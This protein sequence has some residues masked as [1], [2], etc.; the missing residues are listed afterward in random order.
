[1]GVVDDEDGSQHDD[2]EF[3]ASA[4]FVHERT[5]PLPNQP[6]PTHGFHK[7][8]FLQ[9]PNFRTCFS[10]DDL[11]KIVGGTEYMSDNYHFLKD[12]VSSASSTMEK[13]DSSNCTQGYYDLGVDDQT[14]YDMNKNPP[15]VW[16]PEV[17]SRFSPPPL[18]PSRSE[19]NSDVDVQTSRGK[20][21]I[22][23]P[24]LPQRSP[25]RSRPLP[26]PKPRPEVS[27]S[28]TFSAR[29]QLPSMFN[30]KNDPKFTKKLEE[31]RQELYGESGVIVRGRSISMG[32]VNGYTQENYASIDDISVKP[33]KLT[34]RVNSLQYDYA[35]TDEDP[36]A[37]LEFES[38]ISD[39]NSRAGSPPP[40]VPPKSDSLQRE[41]WG[42]RHTPG[43]SLPLPPLP[44]RSNKSRSHSPIQHEA[45]TPPPLPSRELS[46]PPCE[47]ALPPN[48]DN[49][50]P[51]KTPPPCDDTPP[52][53]PARLS[54]NRSRF[55][56]EPQS[57]SHQETESLQQPV[58]PLVRHSSSP[59]NSLT[60]DNRPPAMLP[61]Q[62]LPLTSNFTQILADIMSSPRAQRR[63]KSAIITQTPS[64]QI[65]DNY[66]ISSDVYDDVQALTVLTGTRYEDDIQLPASHNLTNHGEHSSREKEFTGTYDDMLDTNQQSF[67]Q[68]D[69]P[70]II[71]REESQPN[72]ATEHALLRSL[73]SRL[74]AKKSVAM[75][76]PPPVKP[77][78]SPEKKPKPRRF[79]PPPIMP[80]PGKTLLGNLTNKQAEEVRTAPTSPKKTTGKGVSGT[81]Q[82]LMSRQDGDVK[83]TFKPGKPIVPGKPVVAEKPAKPAVASKPILPAHNRSQANKP[84]SGQG[85]EGE[86]KPNSSEITRG[87]EKSVHPVEPR[88]SQRLTQTETR[89]GPPPTAPRT[90]PPPIAPRTGPPPIAPRTGPPLTAPRTGPPPTAP[91][92][93]P[94]LT[95][96]KTGGP[97]PPV[98][99]KANP[100]PTESVTGPSAAAVSRTGLS[101]GAGRT[102]LSSRAGRT[103]L[104]SA[105]GRTGP[106]PVQHKSPKP[107]QAPGIT[108][109]PWQRPPAPGGTSEH[110]PPVPKPSVRPKP[111]QVTG[112]TFQAPLCS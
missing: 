46:Y 34:L 12:N 6:P 75:N 59:S 85:T 4:D 76:H 51:I 39:S 44:L 21:H 25:D 29:M 86:S 10:Q 30:F 47:P 32:E 43:H 57:P 79:Q 22:M 11:H 50:L 72:K 15:P 112:K 9:Q 73:E 99:A 107:E 41:V 31:K 1:M 90:G 70:P 55:G 77:K 2:E 92:T 89:A 80:K 27:G 3:Y 108:S 111:T 82:P 16:K 87:A 14:I 48:I 102:G 81:S 95:G 67:P 61:Q 17:R 93:G 28:A 7:E 37:Y 83:S 36:L 24:V 53:V 40:E 101:S 23:S 35:A 104:S 74:Q 49:R 97:L 54:S 52:P 103:G 18:P 110:S 94:P 100:L 78:I 42:I 88:V 105:A 38:S 62:S 5:P 66:E 65:H 64:P 84:G 19:R 69:S 91:K 33:P 96:P 106:P 26:P 8:K 56:T 20:L 68:V 63:A 98:A 45:S 60:S 71:D 109:E 58:F 13:G